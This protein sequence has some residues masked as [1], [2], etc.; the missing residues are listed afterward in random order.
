MKRPDSIEK[1][2]RLMINSN[3][4]VRII[5]LWIEIMYY[6]EKCECN[7]KEE[8]SYEEVECTGDG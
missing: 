5:D 1:Q 4:V 6:M 3:K 7:Y 2:L 8:I